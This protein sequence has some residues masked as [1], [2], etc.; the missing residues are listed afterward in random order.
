MRSNGSRFL[1]QS[2]GLEVSECL[3]DMEQPLRNHC[4]TN[5]CVTVYNCLRE[6]GSVRRRYNLCKHVCKYVIFTVAK[7]PALERISCGRKHQTV[8]MIWHI[9]FITVNITIMIH[10]HCFLCAI[11]SSLP[12]CFFGPHF[13][14]VCPRSKGFLGFLLQV[15]DEWPVGILELGCWYPCRALLWKCCLRFRLVWVVL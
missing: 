2:G 8:Q 10:H 3:L 9:I 12:S 13:P 7:A 11:F 1:F 15:Y 4:A 5:P 6:D 14:V